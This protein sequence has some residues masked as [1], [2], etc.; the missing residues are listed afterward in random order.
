MKRHVLP[1]VALIASFVASP[2]PAQ[3]NPADLRIALLIANAT[4]P[5][6]VS[7]LATPPKDARA[8]GDELRRLGFEVD[9]KNN[10]TKADTQKAI[11]AFLGKIR[12]GS[13]G[14]FF[15]S[16]FG[17]Q[18]A[19]HN[20]LL[21][22]DAQ[23]WTEAE[24][25]RDGITIESILDRIDQK[26]AGVK[27]IIVD[28]SRRNPYERRFRG[29]A[30]GL[31]GLAL[32]NGSLAIYSAAADKVANDVDGANSVLMTQLLQELR[33]P[34]A[35]AEAAFNRTRVDVS[36][37]TNGDQVPWVSSSMVDEFLFSPKTAVATVKP[38]DTTQVATVAAPAAKPAT[39]T[40]DAGHSARDKSSATESDDSE[41]QKLNAK[42]A[43]N[44]NDAAA[45]YNRG[46]LYA[47][48]G[49]FSRAVT[50]FDQAIRLAPNDASAF[51]N[52]CWARA[53]S[54]DLGLALQDCNEALRLRPEFADALD[55]R[56]LV[57]LKL[58]LNSIAI[59]D[60]DTALRIK[61]NQASS[62]YGRG[63]GKLRMGKSSEGNSDI[64]AAKAINPG[65]AEEFAAHGVR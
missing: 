22:T 14:L 53:A 29:V 42:L 27:I 13:V 9:I 58:N 51:N 61:P 40:A 20:F 4:Y 56:G 37:A 19:N 23:I 44:P 16:G 54:D 64:A 65:I 3:Q 8:L 46:Q 6:A 43:Q 57:Y 2:V 59:A 39:T 36:R 31:A 25:A 15:F 1:A 10:L 30:S 41:I 63:I 50:D 60:Y 62:L 35:S 38:P 18:V 12:K 26:G 34:G 33:S 24:V 7:P 21:P 11:D 17:I 52:R 47:K 55:S 48:N 45:L 32:P 28:A 49:E 5:E